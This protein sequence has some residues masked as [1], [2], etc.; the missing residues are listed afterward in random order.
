[1]SATVDISQM[2][3]AFREYLQFTSKT[4]ADALNAK[5]VDLCFKSAKTIEPAST[6]R[7]QAL[8]GEPK[9][10]N[11]FIQRLIAK[12]K[13]SP[14]GMRT[15]KRVIGT[16]TTKSGKIRKI[17]GTP[18][19]HEVLFTSKMAKS[20]E[21]RVLAK[22]RAA[23]TFAKAFF[24]QVKDVFKGGASR[25]FGGAFKI[26]IRRAV[27]TSLKAGFSSAYNF[28]GAG[29]SDP[30]RSARSMDRILSRA[31][32]LGLRLVIIDM[33]KHIQDKLAAKARAVSGRAAA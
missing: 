25:K 21:R 18:V 22:R 5:T 7:I 15:Y 26:T 33:R 30:N 8:K 10:W 29:I 3:A 27:P 23:R 1:M 16:K 11:W 6:Q 12:G 32:K 13:M 20:V 19:K 4:A 24:M 17:K 9:F 2:R 14:K 28:K 31:L